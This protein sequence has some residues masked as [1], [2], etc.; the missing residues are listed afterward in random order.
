MDYTMTVE[1]PL[2]NVPED[3]EFVAAKAAAEI[4]LAGRIE[5]AVMVEFKETPQ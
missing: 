2:T 3:V 4:W 1:I 5:D